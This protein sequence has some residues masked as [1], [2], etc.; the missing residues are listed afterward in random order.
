MPAREEKSCGK[1]GLKLAREAKAAGI[2]PEASRMTLELQKESDQLSAGAE[3]LKDQARLEDLSI[4]TLEKVKSIKK[5]SQ[6]LD[7]HLAGGEPYPECAS[8]ELCQDGCGATKKARQ[9]EARALGIK[10]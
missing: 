4:W 8:G 2:L 7:G 5:G 10:S 9:E 1:R 6:R 3:S